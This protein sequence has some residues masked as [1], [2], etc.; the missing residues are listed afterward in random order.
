MTI[1]STSRNPIM[2][3]S[4]SDMERHYTDGSGNPVYIDRAWYMNDGPGS[5]VRIGDI[6]IIRDLKS[7]PHSVGTIIVLDSDSYRRTPGIEP[8]EVAHSFYESHGR[9]HP[10][11]QIYGDTSYVLRGTIEVLVNGEYKLDVE[12]RPY[13]DQYG[14]EPQGK[15]VATEF[16][17][18][19]WNF[20]VGSGVPFEIRYRGDGKG[21]VIQGTYTYDELVNG[22]YDVLGN[23]TTSPDELMLNDKSHVGEAS[24]VDRDYGDYSVGFSSGSDTSRDYDDDN[25]YDYS[26][27]SSRDSSRDD[28]ELDGHNSQED[29][30]A[31]RERQESRDDDRKEREEEARREAAERF[32]KVAAYYNAIERR[33]DA[34]QLMQA[35]MAKFKQWLDDNRRTIM[36][37]V[38]DLDGDGVELMG[39]THGYAFDWDQDGFREATGWAHAD[40]GVLGVDLDNAKWDE[41]KTLFGDEFIQRGD[42]HGVGSL[43][44]S[45]LQGK[46][47]EGV[48]SQSDLDVLFTGD[49]Q[50]VDGQEIELTRWLDNGAGATDFDGLQAFDSNGDGLFVSVD[51]QARLDGADDGLTELTADQ[52]GSAFKI[53][54][55]HNGDGN[56]DNPHADDGDDADQNELR[57]LGGYEIAA[58]RLD[59]DT[60][61]DAYELHEAGGAA[62]GAFQYAYDNTISGVTHFVRAD[63]STGYVGDV[64]FHY[65]VNGFQIVKDDQGDVRVLFESGAVG[66]G[67]KDLSASDT[68][69]FVVWGRE[70]HEIVDADGEATG[71]TR[72]YDWVGVQGDERDNA[73]D[74]QLAARGLMING[75]GG[76]DVLLGSGFND[77]LVGGN[78]GIASARC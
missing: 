36:P 6:K 62:N 57:G 12:L 67:Y 18:S 73:V 53:W 3:P 8:D 68:A 48:I 55:D 45:F 40:D 56:V 31:E 72:W 78:W 23:D 15:D 43:S 29:H 30:E 38:V 63:G 33:I 9:I 76:D 51:G 7:N 4:V 13:D 64:G 27:D 5:V 65:F 47:D 10:F 14:G 20:K 61:R 69:D 75:A 70:S 11:S 50:I 60:Y 21:K 22:T 17:R 28:A 49:G 16:A 19:L 37:M 2:N 35:R 39:M 77:M 26:S 25:A 52:Y 44:L 66:N 71:E 34:A 24:F 41:L 54:Q 32:A 58:I 59:E 1:F 42:A 46:V 74:A